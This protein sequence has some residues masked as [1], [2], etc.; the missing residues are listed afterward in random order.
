MVFGQK[1]ASRA[2]PNVPYDVGASS[3]F[4]TAYVH[5]VLRDSPLSWGYWDK[6]A[7][8]TA[9]VATGTSLGYDQWVGGVSAD[10]Y[11]ASKSK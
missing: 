6:F 7:K 1:P 5:P 9:W 8:W 3:L 10:R 11:H 4:D 2:K